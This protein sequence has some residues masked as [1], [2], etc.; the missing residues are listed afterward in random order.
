[1]NS[2]LVRHRRR[3]R[4]PH[5]RRSD[6]LQHR[7]SP[8]R[9]TATTNRY[10]LRSGRGAE[11]PARAPAADAA[12]AA[13]GGGRGGRGG[14][15]R[16]RPAAAGR[17][18]A[19]GGG[20]AG[21]GRR[22]AASAARRPAERAQRQ[23]GDAY[24]FNWNTPFIM[25]P[26]NPKH[27]VARRQPAVQVVQPGDTWVASAGPDEEDRSQ[28]RGGDGRAGQPHAAVEERRRRRPTARS[29]RSR[30]RR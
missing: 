3:R 1:M 26:H 10:D 23:P 5:R 29:S 9:R 4:L 30:N 27:R 15:R 11:H 13:G 25:S 16:R 22:Q 7:L 18:A 12:D 28:H 6:R 8:N 14:R 24:R 2:R 19:G 17:A 21:A 20:A